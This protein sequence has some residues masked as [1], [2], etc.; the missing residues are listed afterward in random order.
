MKGKEFQP[1]TSPNDSSDALQ[2]LCQG[3]MASCDVQPQ[4]IYKPLNT[5]QK[6]EVL[7]KIGNIIFFK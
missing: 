7:G 1:N 6:I 3:K 2:N 5:P 4:T